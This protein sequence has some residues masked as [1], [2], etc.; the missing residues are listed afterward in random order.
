MLVE[1]VVLVEGARLAR[2]PRVTRHGTRSL[3]WSDKIYAD[4]Q[5]RLRRVDLHLRVL[6]VLFAL[7]FHLVNCL[8]QQNLK[9]CFRR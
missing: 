3:R 2:S 6:F 9:L 8:L 1:L 4:T 5:A 7:R